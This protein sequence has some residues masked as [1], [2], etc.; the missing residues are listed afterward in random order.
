MKNAAFYFLNRDK[1]ILSIEKTGASL[2]M[3]SSIPLKQDLER[4]VDFAKKNDLPRSLNANLTFSQKIQNYDL[5]H[6]SLF[7]VGSHLYVSDKLK[8]ALHEFDEIYPVVNK[9]S[10]EEYEHFRKH[11]Q[12][13]KIEVLYE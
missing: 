11:M 5:F 7:K 1:S 6:W 8:Q 10:E 13:S 4:I 12:Y 3:D 9:M 2:R